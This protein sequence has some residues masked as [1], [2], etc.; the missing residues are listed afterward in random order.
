MQGGSPA[1]VADARRRRLGRA[2]AGVAKALNSS[3]LPAGLHDGGPRD[4]FAACGAEFAE[5]TISRDL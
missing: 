2:P 3:G 1:N 5:A 4:F